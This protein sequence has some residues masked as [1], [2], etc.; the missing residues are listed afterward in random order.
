MIAPASLAQ[1]QRTAQQLMTTPCTI[2]RRTQAS[3]AWGGQADTWT[4]QASTVCQIAPERSNAPE[5]IAQGR[6][7]ELNR[8]LIR[9][10]VET[11]IDIKDRITAG[12]VTYEVQSVDSPRTIEITRIVHAIVVVT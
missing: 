11:D 2:Q 5:Q 9:L 12:G 4:A 6:L 10:P 3:D 1:M 8:F 7:E